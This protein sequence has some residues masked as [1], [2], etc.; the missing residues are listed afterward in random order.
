MVEVIC[1]LEVEDCL[2]PNLAPLP[3]LA[4]L[5]KVGVVI[6]SVRFQGE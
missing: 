1:V 5:R 4:G 2:R 3:L 6:N